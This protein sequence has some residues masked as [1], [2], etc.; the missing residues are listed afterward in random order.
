MYVASIGDMTKEKMVLLNQL[1]K[2]N[3]RAEANLSS[4]ASQ[5]D[6]I[7]YCTTNNIK[8]LITFKKTVY[9]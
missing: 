5:S 4:D 2:Y 1:W 7:S 6:L 8:L 3:I 9:S